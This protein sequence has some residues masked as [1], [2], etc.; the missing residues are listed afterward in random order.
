MWPAQ[1]F[2]SL[3]GPGQSS[4]G[5]LRVAVGRHRSAVGG[6]AG[7]DG[8][9]RLCR[10]VAIGGIG[11]GPHHVLGYRQR[12]GRREDDERVD[13]GI[14]E[15]ERH[16]R[17]I[18][19]GCRRGDHV[20][21]VGHGRLVGKERGEVPPRVLVERRELEAQLGTG[22][23]AED[24]EPARVRQDRNAAAAGQ[25]LGRNQLEDVA[26]LLQG[27]GP[28]HARLAKQSLGR[29]IGPGQGSSV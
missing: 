23:G 3:D 2:R 9:D 21:G 17:G 15:E 25:R 12:R 26:Q 7:G 13:V 27:V 4:G 14:G 11:D 16:D 22:V 29:P 18:R 8:E 24:R 20:D 28:D 6:G 10:P 5:R 1:P 19:R